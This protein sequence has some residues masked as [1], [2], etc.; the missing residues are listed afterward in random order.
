MRLRPAHELL[1]EDEGSPA[2]IRRSLR[3][4]WWINRRLGGLS[5]WRSLLAA[6]QAAAPAAPPALTLLDV[7]AGS[8]ELAAWIAAELGR[9]GGA[10]RAVALDRRASHLAAAAGPLRLAGDALR[11]PF[12]DAT[13]DLVACNLFLHHFH[14]APGDAAATRLLREM[15]RVARGAVL[16]NDLDRAWIPYAFIRLLGVRFS[17]ITRHDGPRSVAQAYTAPELRRLAAAALPAW[18]CEVRRIWPYRLGLILWRG[19]GRAV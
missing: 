9:G 16:I 15:A 12:A 18:R 3:E 11:L 13:V 8:G 7:G 2:E 14:D 17:R 19:A 5:S 4:L 10:V 6:W 1:D